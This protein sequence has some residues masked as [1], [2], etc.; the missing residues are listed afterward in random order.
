MAILPWI[1]LMRFHFHAS[2]ATVA[3]GAFLFASDPS[4]ILLGRLAWCWLCFNVL[5]YGGLYA[6]N[7]VVDAAEDARHP[8]KR[9]RPI[10]S[11]DVTR[12]GATVF[13]VALVGTGLVLGRAVLPAPSSWI[14]PGFVALNLLYT[15][16]AKRVPHL[17]LGLVASTHTLRLVLGATLGGT[18]PH[19]AAI[20]SFWL[21]LFALA[22]TIHSTFHLKAR[23]IPWYPPVAVRG[24]QACAL[25]AAAA[26][27][28]AAP[29]G[30]A[31]AVGLF[32]AVVAGTIAVLRAPRLRPLVGA[33]FQV[34]PS[35]DQPTRGTPR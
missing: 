32:A 18:L 10:P 21:S 19:P 4:W 22:T 30:Q 34:V 9:S 13:A 1:R 7:D 23:E 3:A 33:V 26:L 28:A 29:R 25:I 14:L 20:A 6:F 5:V 27:L 8:V 31:L 12:I 15:L 35:P 11:G 24:I 16:V 17:G 2:F